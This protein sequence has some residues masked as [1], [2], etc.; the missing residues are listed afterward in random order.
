MLLAA[1]TGVV[2][3]A[4]PILPMVLAVGALLAFI[5]RFRRLGTVMASGSLLL[6]GAA[7]VLMA[8]PARWGGC[9]EPGVAGE[10]RGSVG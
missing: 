4:A 2:I 9:S 7:F 1:G 6:F 10:C 5:D 8:H 3:S